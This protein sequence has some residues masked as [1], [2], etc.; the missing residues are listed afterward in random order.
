MRSV[1]ISLIFLCLVFSV[2]GQKDTIASRSPN[3]HLFCKRAST[4]LLFNGFINYFEKYDPK[5]FWKALNRAIETYRK[6]KDVWREMQMSGMKKDFS[7]DRSATKYAEVYEKILA[8]DRSVA[9]PKA[10]AKR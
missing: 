10:G 8:N 3:Y 4:V 9:A 1:F 6:K 5:A 7:W 2:Q